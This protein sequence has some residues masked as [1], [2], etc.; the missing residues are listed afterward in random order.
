MAKRDYYEVLEVNRNASETEIKKAYRRLA[1]KYHPDKNPDDH[2]AEDSF[3]EITE[4]YAV[5]S[6]AQK[7]AAYD[8][9]GHA[10]VDGG[11]PFSGEGFGFGGS[12]FEDIFGSIFGDVFGASGGRRGRGQRG[13]DLR[14]NLSI[15][16]EEAAFGVE[17]KVQI[18][19]HHPCEACGGSRAKKGTSPK[20]CST[21]QGGGQVRYQQGFFSLTRPCPDCGGEGKV[22]E[23]GK[24]E[25][26]LAMQGTYYNLYN[27]G[28]QEAPEEN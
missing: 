5:L 23:Q 12:P 22:I 20:T 18:P 27:I 9:F 7:R 25:D 26:L 16:F 17:T 4:A 15:S 8:Q 6:D 10:G 24:H 3:K 19:R 11:S 13:D 21:C 14:Y 2:Q 28:F 1:I